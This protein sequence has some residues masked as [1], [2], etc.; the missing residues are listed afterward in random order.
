MLLTAGGG[1]TH[2]GIN[3]SIPL[4]LQLGEAI[5]QGLIQHFLVIRLQHGAS[6]DQ[7]FIA[8]GQDDRIGQLLAPIFL[9]VSLQLAADVA[10]LSGPGLQLL[11]GAGNGCSFV[12]GHCSDSL[13]PGVLYRLDLR[14][15][16]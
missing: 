9:N 15:G 7:G 16:L 10:N 11:L 1:Q 2:G 14:A 12:F 8:P 3:G 13:I 4:I 5:L 6:L